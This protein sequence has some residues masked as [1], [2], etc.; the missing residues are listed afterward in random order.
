M[1]V[2]HEVIAR[3]LQGTGQG[4]GGRIEQPFPSG[5]LANL[6]IVKEFW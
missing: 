1:G 2:N 5:P 3:Q 6:T 4:I